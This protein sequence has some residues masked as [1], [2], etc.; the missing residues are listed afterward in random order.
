MSRSQVL[1]IANTMAGNYLAWSTFSNY[2]VLLGDNFRSSSVSS[3]QVDQNGDGLNDQLNITLQLPLDNSEEIVGFQLLLFFDYQLTRFEKFRKLF[4]FLLIMIK[5]NTIIYDIMFF[6]PQFKWTK[7]ILYMFVCRYSSFK[8]QSMIHLQQFSP[9]PAGSYTAFAALKLKQNTP[10]YHRGSDT[11]YD[12]SLVDPASISVSDYDVSS[13]LARNS[14]R[15]VTTA[16]DGLQSTWQISR[17]AGAPFEVKVLLDYEVATVV[18]FSGF[19][20]LVKWGWVQY[21]AVLLLLKF[22]LNQLDEAV[23]GT[24]L[25]S[26]VRFRPKVKFDWD[27]LLDLVEHLIVSFI[28]K[29]QLHFILFF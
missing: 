29:T 7:L 4:Y 27:F 18:Y 15:N 5:L 1:L 21:L 13:I 20:E 10:L 8:M 6:A 9:I 19:W 25:L 11:R 22:F 28:F 17:A 23:F 14:Q 26:T 12:Q 24:Q 2:N 16:L 3:Y